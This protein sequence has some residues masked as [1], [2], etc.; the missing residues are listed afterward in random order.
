MRRLAA[1][2]NIVAKLSGLGTFIHRNDA[3][4]VADIVAETIAIFG[5]ERCLFGSNFPI[6]K[7]WT[8]YA[9]LISTYRAVLGAYP[10]QAQRA[11]L[12]DNAL[13][14]YRIGT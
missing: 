9:G 7:L 11:M 5:W 2:E 12:R 10:E 6:E 4:H 13:R 1:Q 3:G 8:D 14:I